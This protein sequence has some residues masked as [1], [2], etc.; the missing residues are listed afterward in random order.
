MHRSAHVAFLTCLVTA[1]LFSEEWTRTW[2]VTGKPDL[3]VRADDASVTVRPGDNNRIEARVLTQGWSIGD[4]GVRVTEQQSG[5]RLDLEVRIPQTHRWSG[6]WTGNRWVKIEIRVPRQANV[7][8]KTGDG[9][10]LVEQITGE[11]RISTGDG[12]VEAYDI[13]GILTAETG[14]GSIKARGRFDDLQLRTGDGSVNAE[15]ATG[16][17]LNGSWR[18]TTG[19]G[20]VTLRLPTGLAADVDASTGDGRIT[21]DVPVTASGNLSKNRVR[22][23]LN[24]GGYPITVRT[25]DG[26]IRLASL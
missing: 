22:G 10:V 18:V 4:S 3:H 6:N 14:D 21:L 12:A 23:K 2:Q 13:D 5:N 1:P 9:H 16:S 25:G 8:A 11:T 7:D 24:G 15:I 17:K 19:D 26:S 20:S